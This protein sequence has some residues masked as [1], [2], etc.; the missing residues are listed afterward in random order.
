M[1]N[2][3]LFAATVLI[4]GTTWI[5]IAFQ[6]GDVAL[7]TSVFYRFAL[8]GVVFV[9]A[10][11]V[12]GKLKR[13]AK[14]RFVFVQ[15]ICLFSFNFIAFYNAT[16]LM[17][18]GLVS[19]VF[20][21]ATIFNAINARL[22]FG[23]RV[24]IRTVLAGA[25]GALGLILLFWRDIAGELNWE[26]VMGIAWAAG[27]TL[28]FSLGNMASRRNSGEGTT[29][30]TANAWGMCIGALILLIVIWLTKT[31]LTFSS[32]VKYVGALVYL[33]VIG[34]VVG[35]TTYLLLVARMGSAKAGYATVLF[36]IVALFAST[37]FEGYQ[38]HATAI[39]GIALTMLGN[40]VMF[41]RR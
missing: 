9:A 22:F 27:G 33:A 12:L 37:L 24:E 17:P 7:I 13:P 18:S 29:P 2:F 20:S 40:I 25:I 6:M 1:T 36:P 14:W 31:P 19:V 8:A 26:V 16:A 34:S 32:D 5:A 28:L 15:A 4:W 11:V 41:A 35:F 21:L 3:V 23:D 10:L 38:W 39:V 30:I